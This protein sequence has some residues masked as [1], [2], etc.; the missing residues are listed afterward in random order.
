MT[1]TRI[2]FFSFLFLLLV[3]N[4]C[5]DPKTAGKVTFTDGSP[6]TVGTVCFETKE[7]TYYGD[8]KSDGT[9]SMGKV[10]DGEGIPP[11]EY[12]VY[13][14]GAQ[15]I[16]GHD[17]KTGD[18]TYKDLIDKKFTSGETS[19]LTCTVDGKTR[20]DFQVTAPGQ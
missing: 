10:K 15:E 3:L 8:L 11:G 9:Y 1:N 4:G 6:L 5:G 18:T 17:E 2:Y 14:R 16:V 13:I 7:Y 20:L 12:K 19:E